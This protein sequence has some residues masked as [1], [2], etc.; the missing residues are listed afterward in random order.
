M[1]IQRIKSGVIADGAVGATQIGFTPVN[2]AGDTITGNLS[3]SG[4]ITGNLN[5]S[6]PIIS[7]NNIR[8]SGIL[9]DTT[10]SGFFVSNLDSGQTGYFCISPTN[11]LAGFSLLVDVLAESWTVWNVCRIHL[12]KLYDST[13]VS[14]S[15]AHQYAKSGVTVSVVTVAVDGVNYVAISRTGGD[16]ALSLRYTALYGGPDAPFHTTSGTVQSTHATY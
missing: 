16:P 15:I 2:K 3:I 13:T 11:T 5:V 10:T 12:R 4:A 1:S 14:A 9:R 6:G 8:T 7:T